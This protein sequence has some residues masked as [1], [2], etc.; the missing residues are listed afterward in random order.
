MKKEG[1]KIRRNREKKE[2]IMKE[3]GKKKE[4][5]ETV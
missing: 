1:K 3:R 2:G 5:Q 4:K